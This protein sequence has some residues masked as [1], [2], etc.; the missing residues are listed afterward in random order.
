MSDEQEVWRV[1]PLPGWGAKESGLDA[2]MERLSNRQRRT[3]AVEADDA[4]RSPKEHLRW[5]LEWSH[6]NEV[7][8]PDVR[9]A[10][11]AVLTHEDKEEA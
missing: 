4:G 10:I 11:E 9:E 1:L 3:L 8:P 6:K 5:I 7:P 2:L